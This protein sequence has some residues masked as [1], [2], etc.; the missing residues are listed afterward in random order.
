MNPKSEIRVSKSETNPKE[1]KGNV[2]NGWRHLLTRS[3]ENYPIGRFELVSDFGFRA[4]DF[5][6]RSV[7]LVDDRIP[8]HT[9]Q[10][11]TPR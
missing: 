4:S 6:Y 5:S 3:F 9:A 1:R 8:S 2:R 10:L 7:S 11:G